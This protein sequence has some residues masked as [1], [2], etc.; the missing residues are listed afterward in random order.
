MLKNFKSSNL[1]IKNKRFS[2]ADLF[3]CALFIL[4][5]DTVRYLSSLFQTQSLKEWYPTL[6]KSI[7]T[8]PSFVFAFV[9]GLLYTLLGI[10]TF[11]SFKPARKNEK[12][13]I[14]LIFITQLG[15]NLLWSIFFFSMRMPLIGLIGILFIITIT[16]VMMK[17]YKKFNLLSYL[18]LYPYLI[19]LLFATY[20]NFIIVIK[21]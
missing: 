2:V 11:L 9:W 3:Y 13:N 21:N 16:I 4:I 5:C 18:L 8:P 20:L 7:L 10:S 17:L 19:W 14:L 1:I 12:A 15:F 6:E